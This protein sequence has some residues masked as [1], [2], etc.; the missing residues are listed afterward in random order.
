MLVGGGIG[1]RAGINV[2]QST[3]R[4]PVVF[5]HLKLE[6][7]PPSSGPLLAAPD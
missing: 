7:F 2:V 5:A 3:R 1:A 4:L 6:C